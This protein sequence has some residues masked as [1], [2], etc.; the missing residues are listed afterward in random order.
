M[1][2]PYIASVYEAAETEW[3]GLERYHELFSIGQSWQC[4]HPGALLRY[5]SINNILFAS[6]NTSKMLESASQT[7]MD[8]DFKLQIRHALFQ[9]ALL[10]EARGWQRKRPLAADSHMTHY[11]QAFARNGC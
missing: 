10:F 1:Q 4:R 9:L 8:N 5:W 7:A 2:I 6:S 11:G 3:P